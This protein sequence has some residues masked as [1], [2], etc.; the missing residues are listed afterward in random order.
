MRN[1]K[2]VQIY[3]YDEFNI[4]TFVIGFAS[5]SDKEDFRVE[6]KDFN[7]QFTEIRFSLY[8]FM[9]DKTVYFTTSTEP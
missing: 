9:N 1:Q 2:F 8:F 4:T 6:V 3:L 5:E 7:S